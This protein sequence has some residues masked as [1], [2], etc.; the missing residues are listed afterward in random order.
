MGKVFTVTPFSA[1]THELG[2]NV[3]SNANC[4]LNGTCSALPPTSVASGRC[5]VW[6]DC[7]QLQLDSPG[8][9]NWLW[10]TFIAVGGTLMCSQCFMALLWFLA[11]VKHNKEDFV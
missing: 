5:W 3:T 9:L 2:A 10:F 7:S 4:Y 1:E 8:Q 6:D 11:W